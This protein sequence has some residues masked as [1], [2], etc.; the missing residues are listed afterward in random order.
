MEL[1]ICEIFN[2]LIHG[3]YNKM[4]GKYI[5][6]ANVFDLLKERTY[7]YKSLNIQNLKIIKKHT[8]TL[9]KR[10]IFFCEN[11]KETPKQ[12]IRNYNNIIRCKNQFKP[13]ICKRIIID[14][15]QTV[16]I[17]TFWIKWIQR[18]WKK[19]MIQR[20]EAI[21]NASCPNNLRY[22]EINGRFPKSCYVPGLRGMLS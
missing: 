18:V 16:I 22:R 8:K 9:R 15:Y 11:S 6:Y 1:V 2:P 5:V 4:L 21:K 3:D 10:L 13:E 14:E 19:R 17:K 7:N 12:V 20:Q